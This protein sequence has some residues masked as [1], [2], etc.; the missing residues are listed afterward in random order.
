MPREREFKEEEVLAAASQVFSTHGFA[1]TSVAMLTEA[2]G[3]GKQS[4][5]NA[6][7]DKE[8]LYLRAVNYAAGQ[9]ACVAQEMADAKSGREAIELFFRAVTKQCRSSNVSE[10]ACIVSAGLLEGLE[11]PE[12]VLGLQT[13][14]QGTHAMLLRHVQRGQRDGSI[15][16]QTDARDLANMLMSASAGLRVNARVPSASA[17]VAAT[18][19]LHLKLLDM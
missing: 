15:A 18:V 6:F 2:T 4:L 9:Y 19:A 12:V 8:A 17:R 7:G 13:K 11:S 16:S 5:Y 1:G 14:W 3:L 10:K